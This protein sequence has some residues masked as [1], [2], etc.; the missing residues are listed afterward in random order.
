[1][2][3]LIAAINANDIVLLQTL[4]AEPGVNVNQANHV[5]AR[6]TQ[7]PLARA[8]ELDASDAVALLLAAGADVNAGNLSP[9][10]CA[11]P[12]LPMVRLLTARGADVNRRDG[13]RRTP[14]HVAAIADS[15]AEVV[16]HLIACGA[17]VSAVDRHGD[18][19]IAVAAAHGAVRCAELLC[20][21][22]DVDANTA[23]QMHATPLM[24]VLDDDGS[25]RIVLA[26]AAAGADLD[27]ADHRGRTAVHW[28]RWHRCLPWL[29]AC[30]ADPN[31]GPPFFDGRAPLPLSHRR[32]LC[33]I[34][35]AGADLHLR[36]R[37]DAP[38]PA[39]LADARRELLRTQ[40]GLIRERATDVLVALQDLDLSAAELLEI[41]EFACE[42][43]A[44]C[45]PL[46]AKWALVVCVKHFPASGT[47]KHFEH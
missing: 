4:L 43:F 10:E 29:L 28:H 5:T 13:W 34:H 46:R 12:H 22:A 37:L 16:R 26:L 24:L 19:P 31:L 42:P 6:L 2:S 44:N 36:C 35:A 47:S 27:A 1:M 3:A 21:A 41:I 45:V 30:G 11:V 14:L 33:L 15:H 32:A 38:A 18:S 8:V 17:A 9:L 23:N 25:E 39:L 7:T 20:G 40:L